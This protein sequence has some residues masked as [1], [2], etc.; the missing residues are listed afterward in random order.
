MDPNVLSLTET[1]I[2]ELLK[3]ELEELDKPD[4]LEELCKDKWEE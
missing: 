3:E 4:K 1:K 2:P